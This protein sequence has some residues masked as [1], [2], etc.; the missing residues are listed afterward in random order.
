MKQ[1][2]N[3]PNCDAYKNYG[4]RGITYPESW[5][6]F[7]GFLEDMGIRPEG[8]TLDRIDN[9]KNYSKEN[10]RWA[11]DEQQS[12]NRRTRTEPAPT[13]TTGVH[14]VSYIAA[15]KY[16]KARVRYQGKY[17]YLYYGPSLEKALEAR[18]NWKE[19]Q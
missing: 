1:R 16:Y 3:N 13:S 8:M 2:C 17:Y 10:C 19:P 14:G 15:K 7:K 5:E 11:T 4:G 9:E 6:K 18:A 12:Q